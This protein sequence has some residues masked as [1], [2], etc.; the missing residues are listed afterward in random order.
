MFAI[1]F[2]RREQARQRRRG[3]DCLVDRN[4]IEAGL[5]ERHGL[6][7]VEI[8]RDQKQL[9][10]ER[11][12]VVAAATGRKQP[13]EKGVDGALVEQPGRNG[14]AQR[15]KRRQRTVPEGLAQEVE[16]GAREEARH[17]QRAPRELAERGAQEECRRQ[18][19]VS[20]VIDEQP[21]HLRRRNAVG[22]R[23]RDEA[24]RRHTDVDVE[25]VDVDALERLG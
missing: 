8:R 15:G 21:V 16:R 1:D 10:L 4:V 9:A 20:A 17:R 23:R 13:H 12:K 22:Q 5:A 7:G 25:L 14:T 3:G 24:A 6:A 11:A 18:C 19:R 2:D